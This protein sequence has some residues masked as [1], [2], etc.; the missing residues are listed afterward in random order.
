[1][2]RSLVLGLV[3]SFA[4]LVAICFCVVFLY[5]MSQPSMRTRWDFSD[6][7]SGALSAHCRQALGSLAEGSRATFFLVPEDPM[8][9]VNGSAVYPRAFALL[10]TAA[11]EARIAG[12]GK[13]EVQ[14]LDT[15]SAPVDFDQARIRLERQAGET[16]IIESDHK[17]QVIRFVDFFETSQ[18]A[19]GSS[20]RILRQR[21]DPAIATAALRLGT[22]GLTRIAVL[23]GH[24]PGP[25]GTSEAL[26]PLLR[27]LR[28]EGFDPMAIDHVPGVDDGFSLLMIPGQ[29]TAMLESDVAAVEEWVSSG[30]PLL[31]ALGFSSPANIT[32]NWNRRLSARGVSFGQGLVCQKWRGT[33]GNSQCANALEIPPS[34]LAQFHPITA[35][36]YLAQRH[37]LMVGA[38]PLSI[39]GGNNEYS[40]EQVF[41][42][43]R[44]AWVEHSDLPDFVPGPNDSRGPFPLA[45]ACELWTPTG[46]LKGRTLMMGST[47]LFF[48]P[49]LRERDF[50]SSSTRWLL[51]SESSKSGLVNL[52]SLPFRPSEQVR[53]RIANFSILTLPGCTLLIGFLVFWRRRR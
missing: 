12:N 42:M 28:G 25:A 5:V 30:L 24:R 31:I 3:V 53:A 44:N 36:I 10:R 34:R 21:I 20:A 29:G 14:I 8:L 51:G 39:G 9:Q 2:N 17:R 22:A 38:R 23:S 47:G 35:S 7:G 49:N 26:A 19:Q 45:V 41:W 48:D 13:I 27:L 33:T 43:D 15:S 18:P 32:E 40:R 46:N 1:M 16:L 50:L 4:G 11:E 52:P 37:L 6:S